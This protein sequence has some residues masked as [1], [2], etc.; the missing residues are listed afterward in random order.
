MVETKKPAES[1]MLC[2][3]GETQ[4]HDIISYGG[5]R[6]MFDIIYGHDEAMPPT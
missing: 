6:H 2:D 4:T 1:S 5:E 3:R